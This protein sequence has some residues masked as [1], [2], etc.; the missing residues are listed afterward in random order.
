STSGAPTLDVCSAPVT[1][2]L[3]S[4]NKPAPSRDALRAKSV[5]S[6]PR[7]KT[8]FVIIVFLQTSRSSRLPGHLAQR[9][10]HELPVQIAR[11]RRGAHSHVIGRLVICELLGAERAQGFNIDRTGGV[12]KYVDA[13]PQHGARGGNRGRLDYAFETLNDI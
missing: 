8:G 13:L 9:R 4:S 12:E 1:A 10:F 6:P 3:N 5:C 2:S 11:Q 7:M